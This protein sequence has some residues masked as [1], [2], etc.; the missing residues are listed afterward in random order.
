MCWSEV[1]DK[2][3]IALRDI[4]SALEIDVKGRLTASDQA[5]AISAAMDGVGLTYAPE[6]DVAGQLAQGTLVCVLEDWCP[7]T[8]GLVLY[9]PRQRQMSSALRAFIDMART[10]HAVKRP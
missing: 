5:L 10:Y 4:T 7:V 2:T 3:T 8:P 9:Y 6:E 1:L